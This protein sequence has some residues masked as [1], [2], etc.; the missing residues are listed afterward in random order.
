[1]TPSSCLPRWSGCWAT[2]RCA[3]GSPLFP[4]GFRRRPEPSVPPTSS[5][6]SSVLDEVVVRLVERGLG[7]VEAGRR[8]VRA[9]VLLGVLVERL[10]GLPHVGHSEPVVGLRDPVEERARGRRPSWREAH[11][12]D[13]LLLLTGVPLKIPPHPNRHCESSWSW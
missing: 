4:A 5:R 3:S 7:R 8:G 10:L 11:A 13:P 9:D 12:R 2:N 1:M 6:A